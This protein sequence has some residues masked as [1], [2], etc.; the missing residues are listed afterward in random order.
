MKIFSKKNLAAIVAST[1]ILAGAAATPFIVHAAEIDNGRPAIHHQQMNPEQIAQNMSETFGVSKED[2]LK[3][4]ASGINFKDIGRA[5]FLANASGK[6]LDEVMSHKTPDKKWKD[7]AQ[8]LGITKEQMKAAHQ[9][10][11][12][13]QLNT[14]LG[15]DKEAAL[16]LL[17]EGYHAKDIGMANELAKNTGKPVNDILSL[18]KINNTWK[19]VA[20]S[21]GVS[22]DTF[23]Q[24]MKDMHQAFP[25]RMH[26]HE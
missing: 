21:L 8:E 5:A 11:A 3:Y 6:S 26:R 18:K 10:I 12:A 19:D 20:D 17:R 15:M 13:Q 25:H 24:D 16:N 7:V 1:F 9:N 2:I 23:K 14:K 4:Q 22:Q